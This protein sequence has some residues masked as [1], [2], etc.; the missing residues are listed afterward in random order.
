RACRACPYPRD[1]RET[2]RRCA[3][4]RSGRGHAVPERLHAVEERGRTRR[5]ALAVLA[6][7]GGLELLQQLALL[8]GQVDRGLDHDPAVQVTRRAAAHRTHALATQAE[9]LAGLGL[10]GDADFRFAT[11]GRHVDHIAQRRL[12]DADRHF[13]VQVVAI[14]VE[15][16]MLAHAH[17]HIEVAR[18]GAR[19]A[20]LA[21]A[22]QADAVAAVHAGGNLDRQDLLVLDPAR[23]MTLAAWAADHLAASATFRAALLHG[24]N[25]AL[26]PHLAV[27]VAGAAG[28]DLAVFRTAAVAVAALGQGRDLD[29][30]LDAGHGLFQVQLHHIADVR[31]APRAA[32][33]TAGATETGAEDVAED[34][35]HARG[36]P[37]ASTHA[38][39]ERSVAVGVVRAALAGVGQ[40][41]VGLL[42]F[43]ERG[44]GC[45]IAGVAV[46]V[47][48]HRTAAIGLLQ[49]IVAS[50]AGHAQDFVI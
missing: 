37:A 40:D 2:A 30:L 9:G 31:T 19:G 4:L 43:L 46:R 26:E 38:V 41:L 1:A 45:R 15:D 49:L 23:A 7:E 25:A 22:T 36:R 48:L 27:P 24:E 6:G 21:F 28:L 14:A 33:T 17:F 42:A 5:M 35:P 29:A 20:G 39:L 47:V 13:A 12:R 34:V 32:A 11:E 16:R 44:L 3:P 8:G 10:G 18:R 50:V